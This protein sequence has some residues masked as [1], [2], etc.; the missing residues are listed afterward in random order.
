MELPRGAYLCHVS[1]DEPT[2]LTLLSPEGHF[3]KALGPSRQHAFRHVTGV[4]S[5][6]ISECA[7]AHVKVTSY[8]HGENPDQTPVEIPIQRENDVMEDIVRRMIQKEFSK[9]AEQQGY[10]KFEDEDD[11]EVE[12]EEEH[13]SP[14]EHKE[15]QEDYIPEPMGNPVGNRPGEVPTTPEEGPQDPVEPSSGG[16]PPEDT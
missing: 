15:L 4:G 13:L 1:T 14:Y 16:T 3:V 5:L 12:E 2:T 10:G 8:C 11:F 6:K 9:Y 7:F